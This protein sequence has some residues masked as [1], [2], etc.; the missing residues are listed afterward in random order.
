MMTLT[1]ER[2]N[3]KVEVPSHSS[4]FRT[5]APKR[6]DI[7]LIFNI[8]KFSTNDGPGIRTTVF[9]KG[10]PLHCPWC[11]NPESISPRIETLVDPKTGE[12]T[13]EGKHYTIDEVV[14]ICEQDRMFYEESGGGVTLSGGEALM[15]HRFS[16]PLLRELR[17]RGIHTAMETTGH[18][19]PPIFN[20]A[21]DELDYL[22]IDMKHHDR[23][24]HKR[25][26][27]GYSD[28][29]LRNLATAV[30]RGIEI[31][32][33]IPVIPGVNNTLDDAA[34]FS[35]LLRSMHID[36]VQLLPFHQFGERKYE[37]LGRPYAMAGVPA[38]HAEDLGEFRGVFLDRGVEAYF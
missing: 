22:L 28:L 21:L 36:R 18:A 17:M 32:V 12:R 33:R 24:A 38:L 35:D 5:C 20:Q 4:T 15:Q 3:S 8:Q 6:T 23:D 26:T 19:A 30:E 29:P 13:V 1:L 2:P 31:C 11:A 9:F 7:G 16:I 27:G 14:R 34:A 25:W 37:M 10:C